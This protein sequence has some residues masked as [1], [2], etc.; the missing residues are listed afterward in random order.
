M[1]FTETR[2]IFSFFNLPCIYETSTADSK[3]NCHIDLKAVL[4]SSDSLLKAVTE[5]WEIHIDCL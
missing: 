5:G 1:S 2:L 4:A 3:G